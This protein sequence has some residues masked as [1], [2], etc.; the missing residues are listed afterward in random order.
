MSSLLLARNRF[1]RRRQQGGVAMFIVTMMMTVLATVGLFALAAAST[2]VKTSGNER[3]STQT[4]YLAEYGI[5]AITHNADGPHASAYVNR[6]VPNQGCQS[7]PVPQSAL[8]LDPLTTSCAVFDMNDF[9]STGN[10]LIA[11]TVPYTGAPYSATTPGS[12]GPIPTTPVFVVEL[13]DR[14][15]ASAPGFSQGTAQFSLVTATAIGVTL[16]AFGATAV[17]ANEGI[18]IQRARIIAGPL[19]P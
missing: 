17:Y 8:P 14:N 5:I 13:T 16:P 19:P 12:L 4:H 6:M 15:T 9:Q 2:E 18:E 7:L 10:W 3:Q 11:P 1:A